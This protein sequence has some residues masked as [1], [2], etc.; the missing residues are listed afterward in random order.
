MKIM[1]G[2]ETAAAGWNEG[3]WPALA[4]ALIW[5]RSLGV[6]TRW[7]FLILGVGAIAAVFTRLVTDGL[8]DL[9]YKWV[10]LIATW[11]LSVILL[12]VTV[13]YGVA[14]PAS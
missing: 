8:P 2:L 5:A 9:W 4:S 14:P 6:D 13:I 12:G 11:A 3:K 10:A 1:T 7:L